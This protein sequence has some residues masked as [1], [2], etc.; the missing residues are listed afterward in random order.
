MCRDSS[1]LVWIPYNQTNVVANAFR[2]YI[3]G[4]SIFVNTVW[5]GEIIVR[6]YESFTEVCDDLHTRR[7]VNK[8]DTYQPIA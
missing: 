2:I 1:E 8:L 3:T 5:E 6:K 7:M 4:N